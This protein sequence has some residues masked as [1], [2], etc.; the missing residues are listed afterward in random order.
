MSGTRVYLPCTLRLLAG[1][2]AA[3]GVG[4]P[5]LPAHAVTEALR[6]AWPEAG[7]E[8]WEYVALTAA[9]RDSLG[10]LTDD[11]VPR[12]VVLALDAD[13]V[14]PLPQGAPTLVEV[15]EVVPVRRVAA[16]HVDTPDAAAAVTAARAAWARAEDG[17]ESAEAVVEECLDHELAWYAVQEVDALL[18]E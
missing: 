6:E 14:A 5:P 13:A 9:A 3:G 17:D 10:L 11:D 12:R 2:V 7:E 4:P 18:A 1:M 15:G 16:V 8:E